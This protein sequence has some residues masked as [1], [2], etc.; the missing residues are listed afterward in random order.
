M[1]IFYTYTHFRPDGS[2]FYVGKGKLNRA[3]SI[4][5]RNKHW[6]NVVNKFKDFIVKFIKTD[7]DEELAFLIEQEAI[8]IYKR[9][10]NK[11]VNQTHGGDGIS[12][13]KFSKDSKSLIS[14]KSKEMW[15]NPE[16]KAKRV[17]DMNCEEFKKTHTLKTKEAMSK[18]EV[19]SKMKKPR[20]QEGKANISRSVKGR[21]QSIE[22]IMNRVSK[23]IGQK[24]TEFTRLK[25]SESNKAAWAIRKA[26]MTS[27]EMV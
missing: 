4:E 14:A 18:S 27:K 8:D 26:K 6:L 1:N 21:K 3:W 12:G 10:G 16:F 25:M 9:R 11:L 7:I 5:N 22:T 15:A 24:R 2:M 19:I 17:R 23:N 13:Y 20:S